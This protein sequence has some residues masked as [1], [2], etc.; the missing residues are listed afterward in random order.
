VWLLLA[1]LIAGAL[2]QLID[3]VGDAFAATFGLTL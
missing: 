3:Q 1:F 2:A